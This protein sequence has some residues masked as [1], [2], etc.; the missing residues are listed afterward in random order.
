MKPRDYTNLITEEVDEVVSQ[1]IKKMKYKSYKESVN[2]FNLE[3]QSIFKK[4]ENSPHFNL[5]LSDMKLKDF[6][7]FL[8]LIDDFIITANYENWKNNILDILR[9]PHEQR[10]IDPFFRKL[11][12]LECGKIKDIENDPS[13][14]L[15]NDVLDIPENPKSNF[16]QQFVDEFQNKQKNKKI[17]PFYIYTNTIMSSITESKPFERK[18]K[19][20]IPLLE[21]KN[22][23]FYE[24]PSVL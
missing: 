21:L 19:S 20:K 4:N 10:N 15:T 16:I 11:P 9:I 24:P 6:E 17:F 18:R 1:H 2:R 7:I 3:Y 12:K 8:Y 5:K 13:C 23:Q 14:T 22:A